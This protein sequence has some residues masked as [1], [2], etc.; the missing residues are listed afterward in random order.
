MTIK[1]KSIFFNLA[2][3]L[4]IFIILGAVFIFPLNEALFYYTKGKDGA[5]L[6]TSYYNI[7][8]KNSPDAFNKGMAKRIAE[9]KRLN[10]LRKNS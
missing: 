9:F 4:S 6:D 7:I 2:F 3:I 10:Q 1:I 5:D 8:T